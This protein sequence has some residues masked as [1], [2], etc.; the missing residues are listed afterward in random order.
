M[1]I[2]SSVV[3]E[4][5]GEVEGGEVSAGARTIGSRADGL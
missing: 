2:G 3:G 1:Y 5:V 4:V